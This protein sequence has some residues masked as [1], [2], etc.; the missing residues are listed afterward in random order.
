MIACEY[1]MSLYSG[2]LPE[3]PLG[4]RKHSMR[5]RLTT[6]IVIAYSLNL[7]WE[8]LHYPLYV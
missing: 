1:L 8:Y 7:V 3:L 5:R 4:V 6:I 2:Q